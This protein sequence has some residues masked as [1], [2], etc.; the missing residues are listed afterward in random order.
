MAIT[1]DGS[2]GITFPDSTTQTATGQPVR[3]TAVA[4]TSG[5]AIDFT[6]IPAWVKRIT[7]MFN[8]V[9]TSGTSTALVQLGTSVGVTTSGY[10]SFSTRL[11]VT[12]SLA[13]TFLT[14]GVA[15]AFI[16]VNTDTMS[17]SVIITNLSGNIW[18]AQGSIYL[19]TTNGSVTGGA[20]TLSGTL[21]RVR[22]TTV[23]GTDTFDAG[24]INVMYE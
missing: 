5:T 13:S 18:T 19:N 12:N 2:N 21:D 17:G 10:Q 8:G 6:G 16:A 14:S 3:M 7:V 9:S 22:I 23:N 20:V 4:S 24:T 15:A 11:G 1:I